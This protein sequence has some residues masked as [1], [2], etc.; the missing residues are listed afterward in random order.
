MR[1]W[2]PSASTSTPWRRLAARPRKL[3]RCSAATDTTPPPCCILTAG[4]CVETPEPIP[5]V[6]STAPPDEEG[7]VA[8][9]QAGD[10]QAFAELVERYERKIYR[11][12]RHIT[13]ND[14]DAEDV[15]Q[16]SFLFD[17][18]IAENIGYARP[19]APFEEIRAA[20]RIAHCEEFIERFPDGYDTIVGERGIRLSGGQRQRV[21]IARAILANP[22]ILILDEATSALDNETEDQIIQTIQSLRGELTTIMVAHRLSTVRD[23]DQLIFLENG[24]VTARGTFQEV[25]RMNP[26]FEELVRLGDLGLDARPPA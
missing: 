23:V 2:A 17:G 24:R 11:L 9:A 19:S 1:A 16:E 25:R 26:R 7:L 20:A 10:A 13:G 8:R 22:R 15:L 14:E 6:V 12:A 18:T 4:G 21:S 3:S 5:A